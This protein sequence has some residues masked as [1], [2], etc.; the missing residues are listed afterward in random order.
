MKH[1]TR[2]RNTG[3]LCKKT[4]KKYSIIS[5]TVFYKI[6]FLIEILEKG[7]GGGGGGGGQIKH[8]PDK[9]A[10]WGKSETSGERTSSYC[11]LN[12]F[13]VLAKEMAS[14]LASQ[15]CQDSKTCEN[16]CKF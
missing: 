3:A 10:S 5:L 12:I 7:G 6:Y 4:A 16:G 15:K 13:L 8:Q 11:E 9:Q 14:K 1:A 2:T